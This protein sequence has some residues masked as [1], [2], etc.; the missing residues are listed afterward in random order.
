MNKYF[1]FMKL[2]IS[3]FLIVLSL[4][5]CS[6]YHT[7][8]FTLLDYLT[9]GRITNFDNLKLKGKLYISAEGKRIISNFRILYNEDG[10]FE[11]NS[12]GSGLFGINPEANFSIKIVNCKIRK[13]KSLLRIL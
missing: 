10:Y 11:M 1:Q 7:E 6:I 9:K 3:S 13:N 2:A 5:S 12:Y 4:T 8:E